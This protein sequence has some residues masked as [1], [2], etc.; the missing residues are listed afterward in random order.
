MFYNYFMKLRSTKFKIIME[1]NHKKNNLTNTI[2]EISYLYI[3]FILHLTT[4]TIFLCMLLMQH[5]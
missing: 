1:M 3:I 5:G 2:I 4:F